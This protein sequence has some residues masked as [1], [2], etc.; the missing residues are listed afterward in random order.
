MAEKSSLNSAV[1]PG[2]EELW[3]VGWAPGV[4]HVREPFIY[5]IYSFCIC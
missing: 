2:Q 5:L 1:G 4:Q 3:A